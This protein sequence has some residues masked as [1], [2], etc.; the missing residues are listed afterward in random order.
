M[1][2]LVP[3]GVFRPISDTWLLAR[4]ARSLA[5]GACVLDLCTGSGAVAI[6]L[7]R[8]G[9]AKVVAIDVSRRAVLA[10]RV[11][12][13][14]NGA[15]VDVRRGDLLAPVAGTRF[16]LIVSNPP[17]V[18]ALDGGVPRRGLA[19]AWDAGPDGRALLDRVLAEAPR[20]LAPGGAL[21]V[22]HSTN[23]GEET[24]LERMRAAGLAARV[25][26]REPGPLGPLMRERAPVLEARGLLRPGAH[27]EEVLVLRGTR[28]VSVA[29]DELA[30]FAGARALQPAGRG[31]ME[32]RSIQ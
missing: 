2:L 28:R 9:A 32:G 1:R 23:C 16:D 22:V 20:A 26:A 19:R 10:A 25:A 7:A 11:N 4:C 12:A 18:P 27:E 6:D 24:T 31:R 30:N 5:P 8:H 13:R 21:R 3:P 29:R 14:R 17:Y 15:R